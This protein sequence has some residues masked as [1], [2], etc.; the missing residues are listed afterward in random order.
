M[1]LMNLMEEFV[2]EREKNRYIE[3][4]N[5]IS[6]GYK[7]ELDEFI[8]IF[9][10]IGPSIHREEEEYKKTKEEK[11]RKNTLIKILENLINQLRID[12]Q[13]EFIKIERYEEE[14]DYILL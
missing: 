12:K 14:E 9:N 7:E 5:I 4:K 11:E 1:N 13:M 8:L 2:T 6:N 3:L 10:R